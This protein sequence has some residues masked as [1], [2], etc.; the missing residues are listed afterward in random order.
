M[1]GFDRRVF[2]DASMASPKVQSKIN[3]NVLADQADI[4]LLVLFCVGAPGTK[5]S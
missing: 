4:P 5:T 1:P 2:L 3:D